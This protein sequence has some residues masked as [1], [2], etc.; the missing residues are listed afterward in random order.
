MAANEVSISDGSAP[1][2]ADTFEAHEG[3]NR[4]AHQN[5]REQYVVWECGCCG[6][7]RLGLW[8]QAVFLKVLMILL[9]FT[10]LYILLQHTHIY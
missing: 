10:C 3:F 6:N 2:G 7:R 1:G 8:D 4:K 9:V 5:F